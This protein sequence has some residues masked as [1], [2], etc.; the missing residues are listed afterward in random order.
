LLIVLYKLLPIFHRYIQLYLTVNYLPH[1]CHLLIIQKHIFFP[2]SLLFTNAYSRKYAKTLVHICMYTYNIKL[3]P[4]TYTSVLCKWSGTLFVNILPRVQWCIPSDKRCVWFVICFL[5]LVEVKY[6][7]HTCI[8]GL[9]FLGTIG[10][11]HSWI[12]RILE[13]N[14]FLDN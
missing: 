6:N 4:H 1:L 8:Y 9:A 10:N 13:K 3:L 5:Y 7:M 2:I 14:V 12:I 11:M